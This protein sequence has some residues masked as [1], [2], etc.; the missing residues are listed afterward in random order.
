MQ[1]TKDN[2]FVL[3]LFKSLEPMTSPKVESP[4]ERADNAI[5]IHDPIQKDSHL[6]API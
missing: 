1:L 2:S 6:V 4:T 3:T 5:S